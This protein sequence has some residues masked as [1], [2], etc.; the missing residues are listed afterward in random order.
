MLMRIQ[1]LPDAKV[2]S[3]INSIDMTTLLLKIL[4]ATRG[5]LLLIFLTLLAAPVVAQTETTTTAPN[6]QAYAQAGFANPTVTSDKDD[7]APGETAI[8]TG[9]GWSLDSMVDIHLEE[10]PSHDHHHGY[11]ATKVDSLGNWRIEYPIEERHL[12]VKFTVVVD[13][14]Q[15]KYQ[16]LAYFTDA[17]I[18]FTTTGALPANTPITVVATYTNA[19]GLLVENEEIKFNSPG[20]SKSIDVIRSST[21][22]YTFKAITLSN[23]VKYESLPEHATH[24]QPDNNGARTLIG[25][26]AASCTNPRVV[27]QP[28]NQTTTYGNTTIPSFSVATSGDV[29]EFQ[30]QLLTTIPGAEWSNI[31]GA[32]LSSYTLSLPSVS[33]NGY[34][35]RVAISGCN[36]TTYSYAATLNVS[37]KAASVVVAGK[38]KEYGSADPELT[39]TLDGFLADDNVIASSDSPILSMLL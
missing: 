36:T 29:S 5:T 22:I 6:L 31:S 16:G 35:Y 15:S 9:T 21:V 19:N 32:T 1:S 24:E 7:Y 17:N 2:R 27:S 11:H 25:N 4:E 3:L 26:Y 39:G 8:I 13:G 12:G 33:M 38:T 37:K 34:Q 10:E 18:N 23:G 14:V 30:W 20:P 28:S